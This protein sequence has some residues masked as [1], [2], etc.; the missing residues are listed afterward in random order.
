[1]PL[2]F[3]DM[4]HSFKPDPVTNRQDMERMFDFLC[5]TPESMQMVTFLFSPWGIPANFRHMQG[6]GVHA[7]KWVN[8]E[9]K[10]VLVKYHWEPV[11]GIRNLTQ[12]EADQIQSTNFNHATQ[13]LYEA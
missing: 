4:V 9:G 3:P 2:K 11:Q 10:A 1:D 7:Y 8:K 12:E 13:D 5:Q 6:S